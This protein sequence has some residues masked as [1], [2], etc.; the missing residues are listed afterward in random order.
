MNY[1]RENV[2][3][4]S[5][6]YL[7]KKLVFPEYIK[8][9]LCFISLW[10]ALWHSSELMTFFELMTFLKSFLCMPEEKNDIT[11]KAIFHFLNYKNIK[12]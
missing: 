9:L 5:Q 6:T 10:G 11:H 8:R 1:E 7:T 2:Y 12:K 4:F 3:S